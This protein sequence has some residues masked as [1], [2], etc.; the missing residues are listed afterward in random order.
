MVERIWRE[1]EGD[2]G[3]RLK[4]TREIERGERGGKR[5]KE[6]TVKKEGGKKG[7]GFE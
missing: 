1:R 2:E 4:K 6:K 5:E 7:E 3:Q